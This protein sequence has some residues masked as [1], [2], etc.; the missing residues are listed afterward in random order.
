MR[1]LGTDIV[2][3][4]RIKKLVDS[5][6]DHFLTKVFT[7]GEIAYC[8]RK[9]HPAIHF[10]GRWAVKEAFYKALPDSLQPAATWKCIEVLP[11]GDHGRPEIRMA[12]QIFGEKCT[13]EGL[14]VYHCSLSHEHTHCIAV[15][16]IE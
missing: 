10:A 8:S 3:I 16:I 12:N 4:A 14:A 15:V 1:G 13:E 2:A 9:V 6:G 11:Q 7:P 5:Y